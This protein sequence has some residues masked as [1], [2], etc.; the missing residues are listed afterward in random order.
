LTLQ[1]GLQCSLAIK[2]AKDKWGLVNENRG[3]ETSLVFIV[4]E[5]GN[6]EDWFN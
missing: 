2:P 1:K 6:T 5:A 4:W 3:L